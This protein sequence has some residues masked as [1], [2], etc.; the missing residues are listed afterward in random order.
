MTTTVAP[1]LTKAPDD[2]VAIEISSA[3]DKVWALVSDISDMP[4][5]SPENFRNRW[6]GD[7]TGPVPGARFKGWNRYGWL[8]WTT[9]G[10]I[11]VADP[12]RE[13]TF[14]TYI[15]GR[16]RTRW[17]YVFEAS[18]TGT[19]VTERRWRLSKAFLHTLAENIL[20]HDH[21]QSF[22]RGMLVTLE[23]IKAAAEQS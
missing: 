21:Q 4:K 6:L 10:E 18:A 9:I 7:A 11:E 1:T 5:W 20:I 13:F 8:T 16:Q 15:F 2:S 14:V 12:G 22:A 17:S 23:R 19:R 3:P